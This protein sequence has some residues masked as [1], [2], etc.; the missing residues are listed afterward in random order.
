MSTTNGSVLKQ[1]ENLKY[2]FTAEEKVQI[3]SELARANQERGEAEAEKKSVMDQ[4]KARITEIESRISH[5]AYRYNN[6]YEFRN[7][8]C[9]VYLDSP[10]KGFKSIYRDDNGEWVKEEPMTPGELQR[11]F[12]FDEE[13]KKREEEQAAAAPATEEPAPALTEAEEQQA[14]GEVVVEILPEAP[15]EDDTPFEDPPVTEPEPVATK[16]AKKFRSN[17]KGETPEHL[18][19]L[20]SIEGPADKQT[21]KY[22]DK[23]VPYP[24]PEAEALLAQARA[25]VAAGR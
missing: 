14:Q 16:P 17:G 25:D 23:T 12:A 9:T 24:S 5:S 15:A 3:A 4:F 2:V 18:K 8:P 19:N 7:I 13:Q 10:R 21:L 20:P 22:G 11:K 6:G 1:T